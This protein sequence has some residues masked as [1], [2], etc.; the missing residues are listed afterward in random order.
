MKAEEKFKDHIISILVYNKPGVAAKICGLI[1]RRGFNIESFNGGKEKDKDMFRIVIVVKGDDRSIEQIQKQLNKVLETVKVTPIDQK[2][3]VER[4]M[5]LVKIKL[6]DGSRNDIFQLV[7]IFKGKIVD[8][9]P[10]GIVA[11]ITGTT[12]KID[13]FIDLIPN[14]S[15]LMISR[16]GIVAMNRWAKTASSEYKRYKEADNGKNLHRTGC[17]S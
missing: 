9:H 12:E 7:E 15:L 13:A 8:T 4:E 2:Y 14:N 1:T 3:K 11:E 6:S 10:A 17:R 16:S 5:A